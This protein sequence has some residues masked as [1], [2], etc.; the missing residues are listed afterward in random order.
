MFSTKRTR[1]QNRFCLEVGGGVAQTM[2]THVSKYKNYKI[3]SPYNNLM[4]LL[5]SLYLFYCLFEKQ[6][7]M[8]ARL[9]SNSWAQVIDPPALATCVAVSTGASNMP[10]IMA[11]L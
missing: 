10:G 1:G 11:V 3:R 6:L 2:Y 4:N 7:F 5:L 8:L 9:F